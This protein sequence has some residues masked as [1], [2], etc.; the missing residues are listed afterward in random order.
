MKILTLADLNAISS[1]TEKEIIVSINGKNYSLITPHHDMTFSVVPSRDS[2][3]IQAVTENGRY[4]WLEKIYK[5]SYTMN[6]DFLYSKK[7]KTRE[8]ALSVIMRLKSMD[9]YKVKNGHL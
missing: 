8:A 2:Y 9:S 1:E 6:T 3:E 7:Y 5:D 4:M